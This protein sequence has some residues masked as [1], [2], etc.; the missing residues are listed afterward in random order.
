MCLPQLRVSPIGGMPI[1]TEAQ[2]DEGA[3]MGA[4]LHSHDPTRPQMFSSS[5]AVSSASRSLKNWRLQKLSVTV[6]ERGQMG[7]EASSAGAGILAPRAEMEE[8]GPLAQ[9]LLASRKIYPEFVKQVSGRSG[10]EHRLQHLR[11][12]VG[13]SES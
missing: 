7:Q 9:L 10:L 3:H 12:A 13:G 4:P 5:G 2:R 1:Q 8:A 6:L 11:L